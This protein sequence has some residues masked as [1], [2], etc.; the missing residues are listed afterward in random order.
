MGDDVEY[1]DLEQ[2]SKWYINGVIGKY[3]DS[4]VREHLIWTPE[5][6]YHDFIEFLKDSHKK[7]WYGRYGQY[8]DEHELIFPNKDEELWMVSE[9]AEAFLMDR[10]TKKYH[11]NQKLA[12]KKGP[13]IDRLRLGLRW[14]NEQFYDINYGLYPGTA[15]YRKTEI[16]EGQSIIPWTIEHVNSELKNNYNTDLE[17]VLILLSNSPIEKMFYEHWLKNYYDDNSL[18]AIV[19]EVCGTRSMFWCQRCEDKYYMKYSDIDEQKR[20]TM[21]VKGVNIRFDFSIINWYKQKM[22]FVELDGHN[23]HKTV[24]QRSKDA[25]KRSIATKHGFHLD[26]ITGSQIHENLEACFDRVND[27]LTKD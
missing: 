4:Y 3:M 9:E 5:Q 7:G 12:R 13:L 11:K 27:F 23:Y 18:P 17:N 22:L 15:N 20:L 6:M 21:D 16:V 1:N 10:F 14:D 19:P 2:K 26:V 24:G 8:N 25:V